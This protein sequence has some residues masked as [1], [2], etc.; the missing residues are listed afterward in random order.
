MKIAAVA[1]ATALLAGCANPSVV[2]VDAPSF[3]ATAVSTVFVPRFE[4][5]PAFV[6][7]STDIFVAELEGRISARVVQGSALRPESPDV[8][9]GGNLAPIDLAVAKAREAGAQ[10]VVL[11]K[12][13]SHQTGAMLNGF[14]T[15]RVVRVADG[16]VLAN[17]HRPSGRLVANSAHH[18][19]MSAVQRTAAD[20]AGAL[21]QR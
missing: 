1:L 3:A 21:N 4:G 14:S 12:V 13:T 15:V 7:E 6:E 20:V 16:T 10:V 18:A 17:F 11:G 8:L 2:R 5:S 19:V 9:A